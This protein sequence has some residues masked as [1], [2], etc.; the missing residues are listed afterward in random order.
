MHD[1]ITQRLAL[2]AIETGTLE[3]QLES[4]SEPLR[5]K[6]RHIKEQI[7]KLSTDVHDISR[8]LHPAI[9]DD[10]GL[11][12]AIK[13][14]CVN[15]SKREGISIKYEPVNVPDAIPKDIA[16]CIYRIMQESLRN[17]AKHTDVKEAEVLLTGT[18]DSIHLYVK[19]HG[20]GFDPDSVHGKGGL[21]L[22]SMEERVRLVQ[23]EL[24]IESQPGR[25]TVIKMC[26]SLSERPE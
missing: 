17:V 8:Q 9:I 7:V 2:L 20:T 14:E 19:D 26:V 16:L 18:D 22:A 5:D 23:G 3:Q 11:V 24:S 25:G 15:F 13:S 12:D 21:G 4:S 6:L 1:D 10:L